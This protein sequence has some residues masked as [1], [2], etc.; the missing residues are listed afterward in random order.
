MTSFGPAPSGSRTCECG[1]GESMDGRHAKAR[2]VDAAHRAA[3]WK[4]RN[5]YG[6]HEPQPQR[7]TR[8]NG[9]PTRVKPSGLQVSYRRV[10]ATLTDELT[11]LGARDPEARAAQVLQPALSDRQQ[12]ILETRNAGRR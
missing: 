5:N 6:R 9:R 7:Q 3:A 1:C 2:F 4:A 11:R 10:L 8:S 12:A